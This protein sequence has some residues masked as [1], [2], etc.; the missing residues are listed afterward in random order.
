MK[1][2]KFLRKQKGQSMV[3]YIVIA[4]VLAAV[5]LAPFPGDSENRSVT[6]ILTQAIKQEYKAYKFAHSV[7]NL[8]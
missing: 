6:E 4:L 1:N 8:P 7:G 2:S 3:E 5:L